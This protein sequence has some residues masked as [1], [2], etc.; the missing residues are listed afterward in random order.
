MLLPF[1]RRRVDITV[2][3]VESRVQ[4]MSRLHGRGS[5]ANDA[6]MNG[7]CVTDKMERPTSALHLT[8]V[9]LSLIEAGGVYVYLH[10]DRKAIC[11]ARA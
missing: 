6:P 2:L 7:R 9:T 5:R 11:T 3:A 8:W 1:F 4:L 10:A